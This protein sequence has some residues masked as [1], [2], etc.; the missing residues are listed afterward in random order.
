MNPGNTIAGKHAV[1]PQDTFIAV[2]Q[3]PEI[4]ILKA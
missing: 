3:R 2:N 4:K 1:N